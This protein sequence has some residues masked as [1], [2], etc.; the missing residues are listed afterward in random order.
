M[1]TPNPLD[2]ALNQFFL[3]R[4]GIEWPI[5]LK[6]PKSIDRF[7]SS[8]ILRILVRNDV[9]SQIYADGEAYGYEDMQKDAKGTLKGGKMNKRDKRFGYNNDFWDWWH[10]HRKKRNGGQDI[11]TKA[12][13]DKQHGIYQSLL[14]EIKC[15]V[16]IKAVR[17]L[18]FTD[19]S[20]ARKL[21]HTFWFVYSSCAP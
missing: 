20:K 4:K 6:S 16:S 8:K 2:I 17:K 5:P 19:Q 11:T 13:A 3:E 12:E 9:L 14:L 10:R 21:L 15:S 7:D 18:S 1:T